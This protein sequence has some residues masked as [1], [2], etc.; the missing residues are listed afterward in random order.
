MDISIDP[1]LEIKYIWKPRRISELTPMI[2]DMGLSHLGSE[3][4][5]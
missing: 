1:K 3:T 4:S 2:Y 5:I